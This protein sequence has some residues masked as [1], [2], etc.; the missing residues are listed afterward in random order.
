MINLEGLQAHA[1]AQAQAEVVEAMSPAAQKARTFLLTTLVATLLAVSP[2]PAEAGWVA[3]VVGAGAG[4]AVGSTIG[5][6][7]GKTAAMVVGGVAGREIANDVANGQERAAVNVNNVLIK[8]AGAAVGAG[9]GSM[10]GKGKGRT[11]AMVLGG[12]LGAE[13]ASRTFGGEAKTDPAGGFGGYKSTPAGFRNG[14]VPLAGNER[15]AMERAEQEAVG[16]LDVFREARVAQDNA[17]Y[18]YDFATGMDKRE[19]RR[20]LYQA[21]SESE[22]ARRVFETTRREYAVLVNDAAAKYNRDVEDFAQSAFRLAAIPTDASVTVDALD[23]AI[24]RARAAQPRTSASL[25]K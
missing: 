10:I 12:V 22:D 16:T 15:V 17:Q 9:L 1:F 20:T 19:L 8:G 24:D 21:K 3:D 18:Q 6:G 2:K 13:V 5:K 4:A 23:R 11:A 14:S 25:S 7:D